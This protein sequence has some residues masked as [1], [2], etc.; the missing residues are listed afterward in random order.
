MSFDVPEVETVPPEKA[1]NKGYC[2][3]ES[4]TVPPRPQQLCRTRPPTLTRVL[5][6]RT[7]CMG[8]TLRGYLRIPQYRVGVKWR[9]GLE[10]CK[11]I[12][13]KRRKCIII[14]NIIN[15]NNIIVISINKFYF[16]CWNQ[17]R[18]FFIL[19]LYNFIQLP[20]TRENFRLT[21]LLLILSASH[22]TLIFVLRQYQSDKN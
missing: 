17:F 18:F 8:W 11:G 13:L 21:Y 10:L 3:G 12:G 5:V 15:S 14:I 2:W 4:V 6:A 19:S 1:E 16:C 7:Q 20:M 22:K 9:E